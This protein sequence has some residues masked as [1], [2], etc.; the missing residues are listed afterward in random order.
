[1]RHQKIAESMEGEVSARVYLPTDDLQQSMLKKMAKWKVEDL[2]LQPETAV[3]IIDILR[4]GGESKIEE[5]SYSSQDLSIGGISAD[6]VHKGLSYSYSDIIQDLKTFYS[7]CLLKSSFKTNERSLRDIQGYLEGRSDLRD[8]FNDIMQDPSTET[9]KHIKTKLSSFEY[10]DADAHLKELYKDAGRLV[11][12]KYIPPEN[13]IDIIENLKPSYRISEKKKELINYY[14]ASII[15][16]SLS[17]HGEM[18]ENLEQYILEEEG[19][20]QALNKVD[21]RYRE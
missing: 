14:G 3:V 2:N 7:A 5:E 4:D 9:L 1:M 12:E 17:E 18:S 16:H 21:S 13:T 19:L 8:A 6:Q 10:K 20:K 11:K 15:C